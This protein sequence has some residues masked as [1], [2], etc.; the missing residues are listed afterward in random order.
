MNP[1]AL[2]RI[3]RGCSW[4]VLR[5]IVVN[6]AWRGAGAVRAFE[7]RLQTGAPFF[8]AFLMLS[9]TN[10]CQLRCRGCWVQPTTPPQ[11]LS[12]Q[13][14]DA[15][16]EQANQQRSYFFGILG[17]EPLL[18]QD[19]LNFFAAH[20]KCYFQLYTNGIAL[21]HETAA[22]LARLGNVTPIISIEGL[23]EESA[24]RRG[25]EDVFQRAISALEASVQAGLFTGVA[26]SITKQNFAELVSTDYL[27][28]LVR[29]GVHYIW[30]YIYR[31]AGAHPE[32]ENALDR[33]Q[34]KILRQFIVDQRR[35]AKL[36]IIDASWDH[37]GNALCPGA[38]GI[39]HHIAPSGAVE[40]CPPM[41]FCSGSLNATADNLKTILQEDDFLRQLRTFIADRTR[42]C[43]LLEDPA[44]LA[45]FM[46]QHGAIDSS[47]RDAL[48]ELDQA[49]VLP[50]HN[51]PDGIIPEKS[52]LYRLAK[53]YY[54]C[55]FGAYG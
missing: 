8:P 46:R 4:P 10:Q 37:Q 50:G 20:P 2:Y 26:A 19:L 39:S 27:D 32:P 45:D 52:W 51:D 55:G 15:L 40:F 17:G 11:Q 9:I 1:V 29:H 22:K 24:R 21:T 28:L 44:A 23:Q 16:V 49:T 18:H 33:E 30:Y 35:S 53:K 3:A 14:L 34:I 38:T 43:I 48:T 54:F 31:P 12:R 6:F 47:N 25:R 41:Q 36:L 7:K 42:G 5:R 13:Q